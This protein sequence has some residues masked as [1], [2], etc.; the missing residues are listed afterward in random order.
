MM[1]DLVQAR[2][3]VGVLGKS[4]FKTSVRVQVDNRAAPDQVA[5]RVALWLDGAPIWSGDGWGCATR[6]RILFEGAWR[7]A[8]TCSRSRSSSVRATTIRIATRCTTAIASVCCARSRTD[9]RLIL[10]DDSG[11]ADDFSD[12]EEGEYDVRTRLEV[13]AMSLDEE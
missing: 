10:D 9:L 11:I 3:R 1:D 13:R 12:D 2:A 6:A 8:R 5:G 4:L 7:R